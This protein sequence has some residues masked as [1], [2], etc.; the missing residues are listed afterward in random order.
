MHCD[1]RKGLM[2][3]IIT[4]I[5][6]MTM[7]IMMKMLMMMVMWMMMMMMMMT[8]LDAGFHWEKLYHPNFT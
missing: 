3:I 7:M 4:S 6:M 2:G 5:I 8:S 1:F